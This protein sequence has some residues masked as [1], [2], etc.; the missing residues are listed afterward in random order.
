VARPTK[1]GLTYFPLD[2]DIDQDDKL[3]VPI[4]KYG[5]QGFGIITKLMMEVYKNGYFYPW[6]EKEQYVF[7]SKINTDISIVQDVVNECI[8][9]GFFHQ[10][11]FIKEHI[12]TSKGFQ[13]RYLLAVTRRKE[14]EVIP[15]YDLTKIVNAD[16]N[17]V[18]AD[19]NEDIDN[20]EHAETTQSKV[21]EIDIKIKDIYSHWNSLK[22]INHRELTD[23]MKSHINARL[24]NRTHEEIIQAITNYKKIIDG[25]EYYYNH[26]FTL[27]DF[28]NPKNLDRFLD[29]NKPFEKLLTFKKGELKHA[30][31]R[32]RPRDRNNEYDRLSL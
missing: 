3:I 29:E 15:A 31:F 16:N 1:E 24:E 14:T 8:K 20:I 12:L 9:W 23:K 32:S 28:M 2:V 21:N 10:K 22:I 26:Q 5:M 27:T 19:N 7:S 17:P 25:D 13:K 30:E 11:L 4:A 18:N 6:T